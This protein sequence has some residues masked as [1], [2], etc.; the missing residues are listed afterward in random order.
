MGRH[1]TG[2]SPKNRRCPRQQR[3]R[4]TPCV[5]RGGRAGEPVEVDPVLSAAPFQ[6]GAVD[7]HSSHRLG[8]GGEE[9]RFAV[10]MLIPDQPQVSLMDQGGGVEG[11]PGTLRGHPRGR[12][13]PQFVV[14]E[15]EQVGRRLAVAGRRGGEEVGDLGRIIWNIY[16]SL[17]TKIIYLIRWHRRIQCTYAYAPPVIP[18]VPRCATLE[19][20]PLG[21]RQST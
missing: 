19:R 1:T 21:G 16:L 12:E 13:F 5:G 11:V 6:P 4:F 2:V 9:V 20:L 8:R 10:E 14:D 17:N 3:R 15:R 18:P 7:R